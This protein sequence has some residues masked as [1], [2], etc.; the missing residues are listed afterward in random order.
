MTNFSCSRLKH[1]C[2]SCVEEWV[3]QPLHAHQVGPPEPPAFLPRVGVQVGALVRGTILHVL[4]LAILD[5]PHHHQRRASDK[6]KLQGPQA[7]VWDGEDEVIAHVVAARLGRV[8]H[9][10]LVLIAPHSLGRYHEHHHPEDKDH[11]EPDAAEHSGVF[12]DPAEER[13]QCRP[14]HGCCLRGSEGK[15]M[16]E[17]LGRPGGMRFLMSSPWAMEEWQSI[18]EKG[19]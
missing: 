1:C 19:E 16:E 13:L 3:F 5:V 10:V 8:A 6:D 9:K 11:G 7:D 15:E 12:V 14:V 2:V 18:L 4:L 17:L